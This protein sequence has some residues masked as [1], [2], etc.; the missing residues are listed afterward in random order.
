MIY[1]GLMSGTSLDGLDAVFCT[2]RESDYEI[3]FGTTLEYDAETRNMLQRAPFVS[4]EELIFYDR[5][6]GHYLGRKVNELIAQS[7]ITPDIV[8]SHGH[9]VFHAPEKRFSFQMGHGAS[10]AAECNLPVMYDFRSLDVAL[11]GHGAPLVPIGDKLLFPQF[12]ACLNLGGFANVSLERDGKRIAWDIC[13]VNFIANHLASLKGSHYDRDG[14]I[15][16]RGVIQKNLFDKLESLD[17][18]QKKYPKSLAR[19][20]VEGNM[21]FLLSDLEYSVEDSLRSFYE[22]VAQRIVTDINFTSGK[23]L[24]TGG[25]A[26]NRFLMQCIREK[27]PW[28]VVIPEDELVDFKEALIFAFLCFLKQSGKPNCLASVTGASRDSLAGSVV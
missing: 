21:A 1:L 16:E 20:W 7:G 25:G 13:P 5:Q 11:G 24:C 23:V 4:G 6:Y 8:A 22:H 18:Y 19:E 27:A 12:D 15:G 26:K 17:Y 28:E 9:T 14:L 3:I 10:I 2:F